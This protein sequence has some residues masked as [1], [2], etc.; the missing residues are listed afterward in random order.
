MGIKVLTFL[1]NL[2]ILKFEELGIHGLR[3][4]GL[5]NL[6]IKDYPFQGYRKLGLHC[7][8]DSRISEFSN[9]FQRFWVLSILGPR[10]LRILGFKL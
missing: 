4:F 5:R 6:E 2:G 9:L 3:N 10:I 7:F 8:K 1:R